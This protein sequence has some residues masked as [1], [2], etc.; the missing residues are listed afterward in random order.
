MTARRISR[1][2]FLLWLFLTA[3][4][5]P[6]LAQSPTPGP[7]NLPSASPTSSPTQPPAILVIQPT[8]APTPAPQGN[9][10]QQVWG[11]YKLEIILGLI[12]AIIASILVGVFL[13]RIA[14][15][16]ADWTGRLF[17]LLFDLRL[18]IH[19]EKTAIHPVTT[20]V[21]FL[22]FIV[23]PDHRRL[24]RRNGVAFQRRYARLREQYASGDISFQ[25]VDSSVLGW[26]AHAA[27]GDTWGLRKAL[28]KKPVSRTL[29]TG[30]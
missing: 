4:A 23:Y 21:P 11:Q 29:V 16:L 15:T 5:L 19:P 22:G 7:N 18:K 27:H 12:T 17:H 28:L 30:R 9:L 8:A 13:Q 6:V 2:L 20:G 10:L 14:G 3:A 26:I 1:W 25:Q 24:K